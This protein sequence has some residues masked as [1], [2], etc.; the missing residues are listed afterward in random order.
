MSYRLDPSP[1]RQSLRRPEPL[2]LEWNKVEELH[3]LR[4]RAEA[5]PV[6]MPTLINDMQTAS[7]QARNR[8]RIIAQ[9]VLITGVWSFMVTYSVE[10]DHPG[11]GRCR[12]MAMSTDRAGRTPSPDAL[13]T[14]AEE[15]GFTGDLGDCTFWPEMVDGHGLA[16]NVVQ[17]MPRDTPK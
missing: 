6:S 14:V 13:W 3:R 17:M 1:A 12:H 10:V 9:T 8:A 15:L 4:E 11:G 5:R 7:G 2:V 16:I